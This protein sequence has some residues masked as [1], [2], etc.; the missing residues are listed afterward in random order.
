MYLTSG[1]LTLVLFIFGLTWG[2]GLLP[3]VGEWLGERT[4]KRAGPPGA[5]G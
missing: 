5:G 4:G 3:R 2:A 1:E